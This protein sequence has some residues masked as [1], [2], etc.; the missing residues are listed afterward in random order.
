MKT[1]ARNKSKDTQKKA[2]WETLVCWIM[3]VGS[4][5]QRVNTRRKTLYPTLPF[6]VVFF[7]LSIRYGTTEM[8]LL[9]R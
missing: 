6:L 3:V 5:V 1:L 4:K 2:G 8:T 9:V 7:S